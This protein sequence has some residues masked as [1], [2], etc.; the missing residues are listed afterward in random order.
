MR[1]P[2]FFLLVCLLA[3]VPARGQDAR[4]RKL[5]DALPPTQGVTT[6][7]ALGIRVS[8]E[9]HDVGPADAPWSWTTPT[10]LDTRSTDDPVF[11]G[12]F[13][14]LH[15]NL[16]L[17]VEPGNVNNLFISDQ[18][19][20][21]RDDRKR[22]D[23]TA[24]ATGVY[25]AASVTGQAPLRV[26]VDQTNG[27]SRPLRLWLVWVPQADGTLMY[28]ERGAS[29]HP[30]SVMA[31]ALAF[32]GA[33]TVQAQPRLSLAGGTSTAVENLLLPPG[34]TAVVQDTIASTAPGQVFSIVTEAD[35]AAPPTPD[36]I[37][38]LPVL[39]SVVWKEEEDRLA[40][41]VNPQ[42]QPSRFDRI[43]N[44]F[45]HARGRFHFPDRAA[46]A[47]YNVSSWTGHP[48]QLYSL[49]ESIPGADRTTDGAATDN[50]GNYG[51]EIHLRIAVADL[52]PGCNEVALVV[53]NPGSVWGGRA[54]VSDGETRTVDSLFLLNRNLGLLRQGQAATLWRGTVRPGSILSLS[55]EP[56][57]NISVALWYMVVP[58]PGA[59][60]DRAAGGQP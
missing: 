56:M 18:P 19:E 28:R 29:V 24:G 46:D 4:L 47:V 5:V 23:G 17:H 21:I 43:L 34:Q 13:P 48:V 3:A 45:Q 37:A 60:G 39:H 36:D 12:R 32:E 16:P 20:E 22:E 40:R 6:F 1:K 44:S 9:G 25:S 11:H 38:R 10:N 54:I 50:R 41:F 8:K 35:A 31:G 2:A 30:D 26:L 55:T 49:F 51:A 53:L 58:I 15:L 7:Q 33:M 27:T 42:T 57:A 59:T 52:P 14:D